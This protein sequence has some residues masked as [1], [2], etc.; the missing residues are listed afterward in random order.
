MHIYII[1]ICFPSFLKGDDRSQRF[2]FSFCL[3]NSPT[4]DLLIQY[5]QT[6]QSTYL[7]VAVYGLSVNMFIIAISCVNRFIDGKLVRQKLKMD[8]QIDIDNR[9]IP[10][11][12]EQLKIPKLTDNSVIFQCILDDIY[13][14]LCNTF[15]FL[16]NLNDSMLICCRYDGS[17]RIG[18]DEKPEEYGINMH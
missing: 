18:K 14:D 13:V 7:T 6:I 11:T 15:T 12:Y 16:S 10:T 5:T 8:V 4:I 1:F 3:F 17:S 9:N 2:F